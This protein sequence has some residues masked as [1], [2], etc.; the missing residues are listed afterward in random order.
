MEDSK[1]IG[2]AIEDSGLNDKLAQRALDI[3]RERIAFNQE[4][5]ESERDLNKSR[6]EG[7]DIEEELAFSAE[8][9]TILRANRVSSIK[10][11]EKLENDIL[12]KRHCPY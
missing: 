11:L 5:K 1:R 6:N 7:F 4:L 9:L 12:R 3:I 2:Q 10:E 8:R